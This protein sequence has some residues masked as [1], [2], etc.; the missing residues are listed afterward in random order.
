MGFAATL[1]PLV[2][3]LTTFPCRNDAEADASE[4]EDEEG[5]LLQT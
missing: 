2:L 4:T 3:L 1:V 5:R